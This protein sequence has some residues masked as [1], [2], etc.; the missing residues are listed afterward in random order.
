MTH[1]F[2][3]FSA[4]FG[5]AIGS[6]VNAWLWRFHANESVVK[7]RSHC[8]NCRSVIAWQDLIPLISYLLLKGRCRACSKRISVQYPLVELACAIL[9][10]LSALDVVGGATYL[11]W[12]HIATLARNDI[13]IVILLFLF[14]YDLRYGLLPD[15]VTLP[16]LGGFAIVNSLI[17]FP[18]ECSY[19]LSCM[20]QKG[21]GTTVFALLIGGGFFLLQYLVSRGRWVGGGDIR[22]GALIGAMVGFPHILV[23]LFLAYM[24]G[25]LVAL[26]LLLLGRV[27]FGMGIPFGPFLCTGAFLTLFWGHELILIWQRAFALY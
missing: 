23:A 14:I 1:F 17:F 8:P 25:S 19:T 15:Q 26:P 21:I 12:L 7:G 20:I 10:G 27:R 3:I 22:L 13:S 11:S 5:L 9:F 2:I 4:I 16:A 6:F 24:A 18:A